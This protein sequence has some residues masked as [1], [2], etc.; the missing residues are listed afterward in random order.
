MKLKDSALVRVSVAATK[1]HHQNNLEGKGI[2]LYFQSTVHHQ[3]TGQKLKEGRN[4]EAGA[5]VE[6]MEG[7]C[8]LA[9]SSWLAQP[10]FLFVLV[11]VFVF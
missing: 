6:T 3:K 4:L 10:V 7:C 5:D 1:H 2:G 9:C 8:I 11:L